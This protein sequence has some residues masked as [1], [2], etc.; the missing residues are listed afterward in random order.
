[1]NGRID[2]WLTRSANP[3][4]LLCSRRSRPL[5][6]VGPRQRCVPFRRPIEKIIG[7]L[8]GRHQQQSVVADISMFRVQRVKPSL[9]VLRKNDKTVLFPRRA[10]KAVGAPVEAEDHIRHGAP[11]SQ[12]P[13]LSCSRVGTIAAIMR[14]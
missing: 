2:Q 1:M 5:D 8:D 9:H 11:L 10:S 13:N 14:L 7:D 6:G 12:H 3:R 4:D